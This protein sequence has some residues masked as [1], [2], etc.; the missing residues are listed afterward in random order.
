MRSGSRPPEPVRV[1]LT[2]RERFSRNF[3]DAV[4]V[5]S[6]PNGLAVAIVMLQ[7]GLSVAV[8]EAQSTAGGGCRSAALT[9]PGYTHDVC[10]AV[11]PLGMGS[12]FFRT[13][14]LGEHGLEWIQPPVPYA[15]PF[16]GGKSVMVHRSVEETAEQLGSD[17]RAYVRAIGR[18]VPPDWNRVCATLLDPLA[19]LKHPLPLM[20]FGLAAI[21]STRSFA[22][23]NFKEEWARGT[24]AGVAAHSALKLE[25]IA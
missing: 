18:L 5:G 14:P 23:H 3:Y 19:M 22:E 7:K 4:V 2:T 9:L 11:H 6:G 15:H 16:D 8:V 1:T 24:F 25:D 21:Q 17:S 12:P 10:S 13:L 20:H